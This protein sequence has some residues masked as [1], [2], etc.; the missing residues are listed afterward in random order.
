MEK[1]MKYFHQ[2]TVEESQ[3]ILD[4]ECPEILVD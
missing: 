1:Y 2:K 3:Y 4:N